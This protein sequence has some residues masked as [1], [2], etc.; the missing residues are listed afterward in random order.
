MLIDSDLERSKPQSNS[1][2]ET[3]VIPLHFLP[4]FTNSIAMPRSKI[5]GIG[6]YVPSNVVTNQDLMKYMDTSDEWIQERTGIKER[7]FADRT[8]ETTTTMGVEASKIAIERA[9]ITA[10]GH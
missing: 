8:K 7:R 10:T 9:G 1:T 5:A 4:F 6:M 3:G 2:N